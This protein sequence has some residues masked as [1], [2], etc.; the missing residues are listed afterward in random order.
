LAW[1]LIDLP[2]GA[3]A[4]GSAAV[5]AGR[6]KFF[7]IGADDKVYEVEWRASI[8]WRPGV[9]WSEVAIDG[10]GLDARAG[11][12]IAAI[13]RVRGQVEVFAQSKDGALFRA[14][15]S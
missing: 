13:S 5:D 15:W 8:G 10:K 14:W 11:G 12:G 3:R 9:T 2:G 4:L 6:V 1:I 7:A